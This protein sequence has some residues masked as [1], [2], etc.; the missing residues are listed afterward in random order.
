ML[1]NEQQQHKLNMAAFL[2]HTLQRCHVVCCTFRDETAALNLMDKLRLET[3]VMDRIKTGM[4]QQLSE[5]DNREAFID[6][7]VYNSWGKFAHKKV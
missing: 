5:T 2:R 7:C 6:R 4:L 1:S 3:P